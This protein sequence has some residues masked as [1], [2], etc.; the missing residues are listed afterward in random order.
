MELSI[1]R[2]WKSPELAGLSPSQAEMAYLEKAKQ[3]P[4]YGVDLVS[5]HWIRLDWIESSILFSTLWRDA[6]A[7]NTGWG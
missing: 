1:L 7:V 6:M 5:L 4:L 3:L 2:H